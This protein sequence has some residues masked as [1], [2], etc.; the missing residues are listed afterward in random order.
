MDVKR[1]ARQT[2]TVIRISEMLDEANVRA[3]LGGGWA[4][5]AHDSSLQS[6]PGDIGFYIFAADAAQVRILLTEAGFG[7]V[8]CTANSFAAVRGRLYIAWELLW[9]DEN[10]NVVTYEGRLE[11]EYLWPR[12][13]FPHDKSVLLGGVAVR[14][15]AAS[16]L[17]QYLSDGEKNNDGKRQKLSKDLSR[18]KSLV[19]DRM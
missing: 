7:I 4:L 12:D 9:V 5:T 2:K 6:E 3:W 11:R 19:H 15:V 16:A 1:R 17:R 8:D 18:F 10:D 14:A 13:A